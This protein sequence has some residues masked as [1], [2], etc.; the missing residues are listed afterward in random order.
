MKTSNRVLSQ[1]V[2]FLAALTLSVLS[3]CGG[4]GGGGDSQTQSPQPPAEPS[5][6]AN[7]KAPGVWTTT[8]MY[9][10]TFCL[11]PAGIEV[12]GTGYQVP[13]DVCIFPSQQCFRDAGRYVAMETALNGQPTIVVFYKRFSSIS[14]MF[15]TT[16]L[17]SVNDLGPIKININNNRLFTS[18]VEVDWVKTTPD[19]KLIWHKKSSGTCE[20]VAP[21]PNDTPNWASVPHAC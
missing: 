8:P 6:A 15:W 14:G 19:G 20:M 2:A 10:F 1:V 16:D 13:A 5:T 9:S 17:V 21:D 7:C 18:Y 12:T 4:G 11:Y 3:G